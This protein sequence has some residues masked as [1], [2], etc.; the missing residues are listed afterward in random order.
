MTVD[1]EGLDVPVFVYGTLRPE[2]GNSA[3]WRECGGSAVCDGDAVVHG[4][5]LKASGIPYAV[6]TYDDIDTV[7]G[8]L[9]Y[10]PSDDLELQTRMRWILDS[11][12]GHPNHYVRRKVEVWIPKWRTKTDAWIYD[13]SKI[14]HGATVESGDYYQYKREVTPC[15]DYG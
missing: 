6:R 11:L 4:W 3:L 8:C 15:R 10:P 2:R 1:L 14:A 5:R 12:E 7:V 9:I 13:A